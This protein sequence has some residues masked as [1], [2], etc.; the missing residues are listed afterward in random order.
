MGKSNA[1]D[2]YDEMYQASL[3]ELEELNNNATV[4]ESLEQTLSNT[5][6]PT[7]YDAWSRGSERFAKDNYDVLSK[8]IG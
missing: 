6:D 1:V 7:D 4:S 5:S 8:R 2:V 3:A